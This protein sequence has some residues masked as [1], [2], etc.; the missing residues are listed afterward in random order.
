MVDIAYI[1]LG[2][3]LLVAM[4]FDLA[5]YR[6][7]NKLILLGL[8]FGLVLQISRYQIWGILYFSIG[9]FTPILILFVL[10]L[11]NVLGSGD[12]KLFSVIS[13]SLGVSI[14]IQCIWYSF[15]AG[16]ILAII[17]LV[18]RNNFLLR[19]QHFF[20]YL[21]T[22]FISKSMDVYCEK[23]RRDK[24]TFHFT[25]AIFVG[26]LCLAIVQP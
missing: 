20:Q 14:G 23:G 22:C 9:V 16:A 6:V 18:F 10:F 5:T 8:L 13:G 2:T 15:I 12:I 7:S 17:L 25:T 19:F 21:K 3:Y 1:V 26:F 4:L 11:G 24:S